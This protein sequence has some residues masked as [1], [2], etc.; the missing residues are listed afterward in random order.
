MQAMGERER[1]TG[2]PG[3]C[4]GQTLS[5]ALSIDHPMDLVMALAVILI[6]ALAG[7]VGSMFGI[8]GGVIIIPALTIALGLPI[9]DAI[10]ASLIGV[11]A[12]STGAASRYVGQ[13]IVN[14]RLGM[15]LEPATTIGSMVGAALAVYLNQ[16]VLS[17]IFAAVMFYSAYYMLRRPE[18]TIHGSEKCYDYLGC[19]Y[20]DP[21][22]GEKI[23]YTVRGLPKGLLASFFAGNMSGMLG[24]GGG[25]VKVPVMNMW[26]GVPIRAATATS[27]F[28]IGVTALAGA[29]V[30]YAHGLISPVLAA[31][32]AVGVFAGASVGPRISRRAAGPMLRRYFAV[33]LI[34]VAVLMLLKATGLEVGL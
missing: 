16:Y 14:I 30:L 18:V 13:G 21:L 19:C 10:G 17:A 23:A 12:S 25:I 4:I 31:L 22:T 20:D 2:A 24:V 1:M 27:N 9:K 7:I 3:P 15:M 26:M 5:T 29:V 8:G 34:A 33:I 11:I 28:M 6:A 32:V